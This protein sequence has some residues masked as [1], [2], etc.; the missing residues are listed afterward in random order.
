MTFNL[1]KI[2]VEDIINRLY[3]IIQQEKIIIDDESIN[4]I[5]KLAQGSMRSAI[6]Y[7][8]KCSNYDTNL[9]IDKILICLGDFSYDLFFKLIN[10]FIDG[11]KAII[12]NII[13]NFYDS[14][15]DLSK[16]VDQYLDFCLDILKYCIFKQTDILKIPNSYESNLKF[17]VGIENNIKYFSWL[18]D[19]VL[20]VKNTI[21]YDINNK[22]T[23]EVMFLAISRGY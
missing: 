19:K 18:V 2:N 10:A 22:S 16:F 1:N 15:K 13:D 5:A 7:L 21:K 6:N 8:E 23:I 17:T 11:D 14:G 9:N 20:E 3:F 4:Y 12:F